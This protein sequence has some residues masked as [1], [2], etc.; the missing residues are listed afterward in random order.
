MAEG[1]DDD[2]GRAG[3]HLFRA[4]VIAIDRPFTG[5]VKVE[6]TPLAIVLADFQ[7]DSGRR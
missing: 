1:P 3:A 5:S 6:S 4:P 2:D 7:A